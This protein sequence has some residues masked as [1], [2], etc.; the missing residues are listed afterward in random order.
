M[1]EH[2]VVLPAAG[3]GR[4]LSP[5]AARGARAAA[6]SAFALGSGR[7]ALAGAAA[8]AGA[9]RAKPHSQRRG[10]VRLGG[11]SGGLRSLS[12][13]T[14]TESRQTPPARNVS[15][16]PANQGQE[17]R[18]SGP[19]HPQRGTTRPRI[20]SSAFGPRGR[21]SGTGRPDGHR[22]PGWA[23]S[24]AMRLLAPSRMVWWGPRSRWPSRPSRPARSGRSHHGWRG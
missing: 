24:E 17:S 11:G 23:G 15:A 1:L 16:G 21:F 4:G 9:W 19:L 5:P 22:T 7:R 12:A 8:A 13:S 3:E 2:H 14:P 18:L 10:P 20:V 6:W